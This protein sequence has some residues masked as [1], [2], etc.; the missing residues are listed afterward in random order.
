MYAAFARRLRRQ[1]EALGYLEIESPRGPGDETAPAWES[2]GQRLLGV[3]SV[4]FAPLSLKQLI[5]LGDIRVW[6]SSAANV[7]QTLAPF[8]DES[9]SGWQL[10]HP[11]VGEFLT[12]ADRQGAADVAIDAREWHTRIVRHYRG[13]GSW[14]EVVWQKVD[15][16]G[17]LHVAGHVAAISD[18][19]A[20]VVE[21]VTPSLRTASKERFLSELPFRRTVETARESIKSAKDVGLA[22]CDGIFLELVLAGLSAGAGQLDPAVYGLMARV[23]RVEEALARAQILQPGLRKYRTIEAI[24]QCTPAGSRTAL[25]PLDGIELLVATAAEISPVATHIVGALGYD[26]G[27]CLSEAAVAMVTHDFDRALSLAEWADQ[28]DRVEKATDAV[29]AAAAVAAPPEKAMELLA[30][31]T[32]KRPGPAVEVAEKASGSVQDQLVAFAI[33]H[34]EDEESSNRLPLVARLIVL[35]SGQ[36]SDPARQTVGSLR[37]MLDQLLAESAASL[38]CWGVVSTAGLLHDKDSELATRVLR[39]CDRPEVDSVLA[40]TLVDAARTWVAW[41][42]PEEAR[43][44]LTRALDSYRA[45]G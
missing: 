26:L 6:E 12:T 45:L 34:L 36:N 1:I 4:A 29:L 2:V 37:T 27:T 17:L 44:R 22:L 18:D 14:A 38:S 39:M 28:Y 33:A 11:S 10:F 35:L 20:A 43:L 23:G 8:L 40:D 31:M 41:G 32:S 19:P 3:L 7:L 21:L 30:R 16:Y 15:S 13:S 5:T 24:W 25:G 9:A 42:K